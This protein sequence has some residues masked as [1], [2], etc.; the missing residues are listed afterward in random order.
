MSELILKKKTS[1]ISNITFA[2]LPFSHIS[3]LTAILSTLES[4][5]LCFIQTQRTQNLESVNLKCVTYAQP[6]PLPLNKPP[7][8]GVLTFGLDGDVQLTSQT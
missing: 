4:T 1:K 7:R 8:T 6:I 5:S 3:T 2:I